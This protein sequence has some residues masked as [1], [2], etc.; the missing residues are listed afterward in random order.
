MRPVSDLYGKHQN[1]DIYVVGSGTSVR[2]FPTAFLEDKITIGLNMAWKVAPVNYGITIGP[3]LN[4]PEFMEGERPHPEI[5]WIT[6]GDKAKRVLTAEQFQHADRNFYHFDIRKGRGTN[7]GDWVS[8]TG[9][10]LEYVRRPTANYLYQWSSI[11]QT[12][13]NLAANMGARNV[14]LVGCD[15][16]SL[17]DNHHAHQQHTKWLGE[18][19][20]YRYQQYYDG[21]IEVRAALR[22]RGVNL[23]SLTPFLK[24]DDPA[25]DFLTLCRDLGKRELITPTEDLSER[26]HPR[27]LQQQAAAEA[28]ASRP[29]AQSLASTR[30]LLRRARAVGRRAMNRTSSS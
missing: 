6:K 22:E 8:D 14:I 2:V 1:S 16:C 19:P 21:L 24:L 9:R 11:S 17:L 20:D 28:A 10:E 18:S 26:D 3:H 4:I 13:S 25:K 27:R 12:A 15:N 29:P 7:S 23:L 30:A 5:T